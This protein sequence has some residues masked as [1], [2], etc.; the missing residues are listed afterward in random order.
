RGD[1]VF[2][3]RPEVRQNAPGLNCSGY[4]LAAAR[5]LFRR[6]ISLVEAGR[7]RSGDSGPDSPHGQD[8]DLGRDLILNISEGLPRALLLP[9]RRS[10]PVEQ[11]TAFCPRGFD[12]HASDTWPELF[13][14]LRPGHVYLLSFNK[15][16]GRKKLLRHYHVAILSL[17]AAGDVWLHQ[18]TGAAGRS[19]GR[20]LS[21]PENLALFLRAFAN[22]GTARKHI[23]VLEVRLPS[24]S[25]C[26]GAAGE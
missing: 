24:S 3:A 10:L 11:A 1:Y 18:T 16:V 20:N 4:V 2:F 15:E 22:T 19:Y 13:S 14:R 7:D 5:F 23:L 26:A 21:R 9:G 17:D 6:D 12:L 8:W 25:D